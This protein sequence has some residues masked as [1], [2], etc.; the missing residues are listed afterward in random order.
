MINERCGICDDDLGPR[1]R[2]LCGAC[3]FAFN[4]E[5]MD[6]PAVAPTRAGSETEES[7]LHRGPEGC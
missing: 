7:E 5:L 3:V 6:T 2:V 4:C 1:D